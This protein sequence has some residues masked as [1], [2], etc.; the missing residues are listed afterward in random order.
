M[1]YNAANREKN[2]NWL[3]R[4]ANAFDV[5]VRD[6]SDKSVMFAVQGPNSIPMM[7]NL[8]KI[9]LT[10]IKR[11]WVNWMKING[12]TTLFMR[13]GYTGEDG[14]ELIL[15]DISTSTNGMKLWEYLLDEGTKFQIKACG[16]GARDSLRLEA[17]F[18]LY[19]NDLTEEITPYEAGL[20]FVVKLSKS[21]FIGREALL[22]QKKMGVSNIRVGL[23]M[24]DHG[25]PRRGFE[26]FKGKNRVGYVSSGGYSPILKCGIAMGYVQPTYST[27]ETPINID[28]RGRSLT[29]TIVKMPFYDI[30]RFGWRRIIKD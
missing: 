29:A 26:L 3:V 2:Y 24:V 28:V 17:G 12:L 13:S 16:L 7:Q 22:Q 6:I 10:G 18:C 5:E 15:F 27:V 21:D 23:K 9:D 25:I 4:H 11:F 30:E 14:C 20:D 1:V 19:G 8:T